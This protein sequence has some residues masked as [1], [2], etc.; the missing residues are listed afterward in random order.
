[1][2][3]NKILFFILAFVLIAS[4]IGCT[5]RQMRLNR[6][7]TR[8]GV[9]RPNNVARRNNLVNPNI[10]PG[11]NITGR[12]TIVNPN[13]RTGTNSMT[14]R[15]T[16]VNPNTSNL[17]GRNTVNDPNLRNN[18]GSITGGNVADTDLMARSNFIAKRIT[19][20]NEVDKASVIIT[21]DTALVGVDIK[22]NI[23]G[24][25]TTDLK[26]RIETSVR[27]TDSRIKKCSCNC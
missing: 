7:Q 9:E 5:P 23:Q 20:L 17:I 2:K 13:D 6:T 10:G 1:M 14:G 24:K 12:N 4:T 22:N 11:P 16:I 25:L 15:N 26:R 3:K 27:N 18:V 8:L 19:D 21:G